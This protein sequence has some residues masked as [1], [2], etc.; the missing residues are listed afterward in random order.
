LRAPPRNKER[1]AAGYE[2]AARTRRKT[3]GWINEFHAEIVID[4]EIY[5]AIV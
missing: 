2:A 5:I 4:P 1:Q 3:A